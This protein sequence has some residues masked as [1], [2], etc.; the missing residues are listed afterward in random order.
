MSA[1]LPS[2]KY[3]PALL[4]AGGHGA[5]VPAPIAAGPKVIRVRTAVIAIGAIATLALVIGGASGARLGAQAAR[6]P[7]SPN[8][9]SRAPIPSGTL[10]ECASDMAN[11]V[12]TIARMPGDVAAQVVAQL[13]PH[14]AAATSSLDSLVTVDALPPRPDAPTLAH[15]LA[16]QRDS[17]RRAVLRALPPEQLAAVEAELLETSL[18]YMTDRTPPPC[19]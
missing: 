5:S 10:G 3:P 11:L 2:G 17:T 9:S 14:A 18:V 4:R 12:T 7:A 15:V 6:N 1:A 19:P 13:P 16:R 8:V